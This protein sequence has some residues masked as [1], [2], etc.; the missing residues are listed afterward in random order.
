M[1]TQ[2]GSTGMGIWCQPREM[3]VR[4]VTALGAWLTVPGNSVPRYLADIPDVT[5]AVKLVNVRF[6]LFALNLQHG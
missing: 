1:S 5:S 6:V 3:C 2:D 4:N